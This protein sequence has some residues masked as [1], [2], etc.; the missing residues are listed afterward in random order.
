MRARR[1]LRKDP[2][3]LHLERLSPSL[4]LRFFELVMLD[5]WLWTGR[6]CLLLLNGLA[7]PSTRHSADSKS[8]RQI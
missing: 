3:P 5:D 8:A 6:L 4:P 1:A 7:F 2:F